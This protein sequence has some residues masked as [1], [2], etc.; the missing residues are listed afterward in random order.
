VKLNFIYIEKDDILFV[1]GV[2]Y[3]GEI[4]RKLGPLGFPI[5]TKFKIVSRANDGTVTIEKVKESYEK[6]I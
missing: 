2:K 3:D 6:G 1:E 4:F 5:G